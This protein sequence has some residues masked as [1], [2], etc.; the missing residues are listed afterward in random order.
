MPNKSLLPGLERCGIVALCFD[1]II[2]VSQRYS[3][4]PSIFGINVL[5]MPI[6]HLFIPLLTTFSHSYY[7]ELVMKPGKLQRN[8]QRSKDLCWEV[9]D[10][11]RHTLWLNHVTFTFLFVSSSGIN[12]DL[13]CLCTVMAKKA[14]KNI[15]QRVL[16]SFIAIYLY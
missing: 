9:H 13:L 7:K 14:N 12:H 6:I 8:K 10:L 3:S 2:H 16:P 15:E 5:K 1:S 4:Y 11:Y